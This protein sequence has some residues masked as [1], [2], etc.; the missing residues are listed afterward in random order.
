VL[1]RDGVA[2]VWHVT[3]DGAEVMLPETL[4]GVL[5]ARID[6]LA[7]ETKRV[8]RLASVIGRV[9]LYR[10]LAAIAAA[11]TVAWEERE[12]EDCLAT[13]RQ[14][15]F[16]RLRARLPELEYVFRHELTREAAY[17]GLL[18]RDRRTYHAKVARALEVLSP[19]RGAEQA[20]LLAHH[21]EQAG[22]AGKAIDYLQQAGDRARRLY[23]HKE[24]IGYYER[25]LRLLEDQGETGQAARTLMKL[26]LTH[27][28]A[29]DFTASKR[30]YDEGFR[31]WQRGSGAEASDRLP[32]APHAFRVAFPGVVTLD[33]T[34]V[35]DGYSG[36][37]VE[38]LFSG[39][40]SLTPELDVA[41]DVAWRWDVLDDGR[42]YIFQLRDDVVWSDGVP[43]TAHDFEYAC[44][45]ALD[46]DTLSNAALS[47]HFREPKASLE[48]SEIRGAQSYY[49]SAGRDPDTLGVRAL[50]DFTLEVEL[51]E[52]IGYFLYLA[53][54]GYG[55]RAIPRHAVRA[56]GLEWAEPCNLVTSGPFRLASRERNVRTILER[57]PTYHGRC[58]G[59]VQRVELI[60]APD[61]VDAQLSAYESD[62]LDCIDFIDITMDLWDQVRSRHAGEYV[63]I[64]LPATW[65]LRFDMERPP[66]DDVRVRQAFA[67]SVDREWL[68]NVGLRGYASPATGSL[69]PPGLPGHLP[70]AGHGY[71]PGRA[72]R[73]LAEAGYPGGHGFPELAPVPAVGGYMMTMYE[74]L[75]DQ[76][77][78]NLG[79]E[80]RWREV[81]TIEEILSFLSRHKPQLSLTNWG[82][83]YPDPDN[84]LRQVEVAGAGASV[85]ASYRSLVARARTTASLG[86]RLG[87][88]ALASGLLAEQAIVSPILHDK[89]HLLIKPWVTRPPLPGLGA[90][91]FEDVVIEPH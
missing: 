79:V 66:F 85:E 38:H 43:V 88:Y 7:E 23:A 61:L 57:D 80:W 63:S 76:W 14:E 33:P 74:I 17:N 90:L 56:H 21:W 1:A 13:L 84:F 47:T 10:V 53:A 18:R 91:R 46:P 11:T 12:L 25:V 30:A 28:N 40:V 68:A 42:R 27:H 70:G 2:G 72:Q 83:D 87:L 5:M 49:E 58:L 15:E 29:F 60:A 54:G 81:H 8:L 24:A 20:G 52:P 62:E 16:I 55:M 69:V 34:L 50:D 3:G 32:P 48:L 44:R 75:G 4:Q 39:L 37:V 86:G 31:L 51:A 73:L 65:H 82:A 64:P 78:E 77:L 9:F 22:E 67:L 6:R 59:N 89:E 45:R 71:D 19:E 35:R 41:P 36:R 26:G